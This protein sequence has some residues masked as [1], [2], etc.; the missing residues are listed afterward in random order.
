MTP[1]EHLNDCV[2]CG[3]INGKSHPLEECADNYEKITQA[4]ADALDR[5]KDTI[6]TL[7]RL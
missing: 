4:I 2:F 3:M 1:Y 6:Q 5:F 7:S